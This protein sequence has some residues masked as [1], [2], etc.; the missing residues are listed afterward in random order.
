[1]PSRLQALQ[2]QVSLYESWSLVEMLV[3]LLPLSLFDVRGIKLLFLNHEI[4]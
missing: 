3:V 1:M 2:A 4:V